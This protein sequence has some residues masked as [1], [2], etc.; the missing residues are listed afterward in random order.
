MSAGD[1][2]D[3]IMQL[4]KLRTHPGKQWFFPAVICVV[5]LLA[6]AAV[7]MLGLPRPIQHAFFGYNSPWLFI[8]S[9][10]CLYLAYRLP[11]WGG[12]LAGFSAT[13]ILFAMQLAAVWR[14]GMSKSFF[15]LGG[16]LPVSDASGYYAGALQVLEG[17]TLN[18]YA[19]QRPLFSGVLATLLGLTHQNLQAALALFVLLNAIASFFLAR[20]VQRSHGTAAGVVVLATLFMFY[21]EYIGTAM[22]ENLGLALGAVGLAVL[23]RG[24]VHQHLKFCL[25]G[26]FVL[27]LALNARA[28][29]FF[30]LPAL[31]VW[32]AWAWR[33]ASRFSPRFLLGGVGAV[34]L[35]FL[36]NAL[37]FN[38]I[39]NPH[40]VPNAHFSYN[41]YGLIVNGNWET[42]FIHHPELRTLADI[43]QTKRIYELTLEALYANPLALVWGCWRAWTYF[44]WPTFIFDSVQNNPWKFLLLLLSLVALVIGYRQRH[45]SIGAFILT[46]AIGIFLSIPFVPPWDTGM[47]A[48][49]ATMPFLSLLP[50]LGLRFLAQKTKWY[51]VPRNSQ[52]QYQPYPLWLF[53]VSLACF[54]IGGPMVTKLWCSRP[55]FVAI[56]CPKG[57]EPIYVRN[58]LGSSLTLV[59][60]DALQETNLPDLRLG[61]FQRHLHQY[62]LW[63]GRLRGIPALT[64]ELRDV[65]ADTTLLSKLDLNSQRL[66]WVIANK[67]MV[68]KEKGIIGVCGRK[69]AIPELQGYRYGFSLFYADSMQLVEEVHAG[70][71]L[72]AHQ[73]FT[74][75]TLTLSPPPF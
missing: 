56:S 50:A 62:S 64:S 75:F 28:G 45:T 26:M 68:P 40:T 57:M 72:T 46:S 43:Q 61:D 22:T 35:G 4:Q 16:L 12:R 24:A 7:L 71:A 20:E 70:R 11:R 23:W 3:R 41:L 17:N 39:G 55:H 18:V 54:S 60:D 30:I 73:A 66:W 15:L 69:T 52:Q 29:T 51:K 27:T 58:S 8:A 48:Y 10:T 44:L 5:G 21:R 74:P 53:T 59:D 63:N 37:V 32:G 36:A 38:V 47:R 65:P 67:K 42:I 25:L 19:S 14:S 31:I 49:A 6:Y 2:K 33:G 9:L 1:W 34:L 13:L